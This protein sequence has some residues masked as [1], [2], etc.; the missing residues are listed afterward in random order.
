MRLFIALVATIGSLAAVGGTVSAAYAAG[1]SST[2]TGN[3]I[4]YP[5]CTSKSLPKDQAFGIV[6]V[7]GGRANTSN[8]CF[9]S[10]LA[11]AQGSKGGTSQPPAS[12][13][14]NT[15]N[16]GDVAGITDWPNDNTYGPG[17]TAPYPT[18]YGA[19]TAGPD[20]R[21][22]DNEACAWQYGWNRA[23]DDATARVPSVALTY[24]W[25]LDVETANSWE[26][27]SGQREANDRADLEGM[28]AYLQS[29]G[30]TVG[31][32]STSYQ[33]GQIAGT[34]E[35]GSSLAGLPNWIPGARTLKQAQSNCALTPF[36]PGSRVT[37][38]QWTGSID[39]D[40]SCLV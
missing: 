24:P 8:P 12:L 34:L 13:Y 17:L 28:V 40:F 33:W 11:W 39:G 36:T 20:G 6:G 27:G 2:P 5:Q 16:P 37:L 26:I 21:G 32:Y 35:A 18:Y 23:Y 22:L 31:L 4:S 1:P 7:N 38:T 14:V 3:D 19:C 9:K 29:I 15:G 25:W 10:E 30:V